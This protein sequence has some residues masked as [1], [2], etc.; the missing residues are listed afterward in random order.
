MAFGFPGAYD[1]S[2]LRS[3][4]TRRVSPT[5]ARDGMIASQ[6]PLVSATGLRVLANGGN[7]IDAAVAAALV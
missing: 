6:H 4:D 7:A 5:L 3:C 2:L 1:A